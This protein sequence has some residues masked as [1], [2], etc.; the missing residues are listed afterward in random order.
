[1]KRQTIVP[2]ALISQIQSEHQKALAAMSSGLPLITSI[3]L[4]EVKMRILRPGKPSSLE[5]VIIPGIHIYTRKN[6]LV[7]NDQIASNDMI[8]MLANTGQPFPLAHIFS[9]SGGVCLG[10][11]FVPSMIS[12]YTP[13]QPFDTLLLHNDRHVAHG[14]ANLKLKRETVTKVFD[15]LKM[16]NIRVSSHAQ[17]TFK[18]GTNL[19]ANDGI[20]ILSADVLASCD[21]LAL[22][23]GI[24][25]DIYRIIFNTTPN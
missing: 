19:I 9:S 23:L 10:N 7:T 5:S 12:I 1:M 20:W 4:R 2:Q 22:A 21:S 6:Q 17:S 18:D 24:M 8:Y 16:V 3:P 25:D 11:I 14:G 15:Y 13:Q